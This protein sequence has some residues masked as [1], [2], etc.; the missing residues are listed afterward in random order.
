M[1]L[2]FPCTATASGGRTVHCGVM[3]ILVRDGEPC[4]KVHGGEPRFKLDVKGEGK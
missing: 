2:H 3:T 1:A 4:C